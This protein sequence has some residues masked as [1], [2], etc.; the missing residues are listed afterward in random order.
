M[1][2]KMHQIYFPQGPRSGPSWEAYAVPQ[3]F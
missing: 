3:T 1:T 2:N